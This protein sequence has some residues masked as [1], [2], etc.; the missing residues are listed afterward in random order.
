MDKL[1]YLVLPPIV[2]VCAAVVVC[3]IGTID[4]ERDA[5]SNMVLLQLVTV[6]TK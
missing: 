3:R 6:T 2:N 4:A 1:T 5:C